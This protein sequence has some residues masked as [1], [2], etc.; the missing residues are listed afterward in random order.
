MACAPRAQSFLRASRCHGAY[1]SAGAPGMR[2]PLIFS[3]LVAHPAARRL[4]RS[5]A[6]A[7]R[8]HG[9]MCALYQGM[10]FKL[11]KWANK[12]SS[13]YASLNGNAH[14]LIIPELFE[15]AASPSRIQYINSAAA[16]AHEIILHIFMRPIAGLFLIIII[17][18]ARAARSPSNYRIKIVSESMRRPWQRWPS[19]YESEYF[20]GTGRYWK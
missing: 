1:S 17:I 6:S 20:N 9:A 3:W 5:A 7:A 16:P 11:A 15:H 10:S 4:A 18:I 14:A 12:S 13:R 8:I 2:P 19:L